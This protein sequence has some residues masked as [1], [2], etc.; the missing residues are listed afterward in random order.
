MRDRQTTGSDFPDTDEDLRGPDQYL[1]P[2]EELLIYTPE[3]QIKKFTFDAYLTD[4]RLFLTDPGQKSPGVTA[5]EIPRESIIDGYLEHSSLQE[6]ILVLSIR[7]SEDDIRTMKMTFVH[8]GKD[9]VSE[10]EEWMHL[11]HHSRRPAPS[12][13]A[14]SQETARKEPVAPLSPEA[15]ALSETMVFPSP[16]PRREEESPPPRRAPAREESPVPSPAAPPV[17]KGTSVTQIQFCYHCGHRIPPA[18]NFCP[19]CGTR[20][21]HAP[22]GAALPVERSPA[23][24]S[25]SLEPEQE[26]ENKRGFWRFFRRK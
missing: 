22:A 9:R 23:R 4:A 7:T 15:R 26:K 12:R 21:V 2:G 17:Q 10:A 25:K 24:P 1:R 8:T 20:M 18:A 19:Y 5:K 16:P 3:I 14:S 11:I 13:E 6:P